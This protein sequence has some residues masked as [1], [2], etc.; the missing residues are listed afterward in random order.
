MPK[1]VLRSCTSLPEPSWGKGILVPLSQVK[2]HGQ[3][4]VSSDLH[5]LFSG[6][7]SGGPCQTF[8][9]RRCHRIRRQTCCPC[10][11]L[12]PT[13]PLGHPS[14]AQFHPLLPSS[15]LPPHQEVS[16]A[17]SV[18][19]TACPV[20]RLP[21]TGLSSGAAGLLPALDA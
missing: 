19:L 3:Q 21:G 17:A 6:C 8:R 5:L 14:L 16:P 10:S 18:T 4:W 1:L 20:T 7:Q 12:T 2:L 9:H 13:L 15:T 11:L